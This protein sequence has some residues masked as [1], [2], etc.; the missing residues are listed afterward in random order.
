LVTVSLLKS[1]IISFI[2]GHEFTQY[3]KASRILPEILF[4]C[5][6]L[7]DQNIPYIKPDE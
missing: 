7:I 2:L 3:Y 5:T 1:M 4:F 6:V